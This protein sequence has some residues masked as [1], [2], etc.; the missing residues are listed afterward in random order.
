M[1]P[2]RIATTREQARNQQIHYGTGEAI[3]YYDHWTQE[4][5]PDRILTHYFVFNP[6][7]CKEKGYLQYLKEYINDTYTGNYFIDPSTKQKWVWMA[8]Q[9]KYVIPDD[10]NPPY[11]SYYIATGF[12]GQKTEGSKKIDFDLNRAEILEV[13]NRQLETK[14]NSTKNYEKLKIGYSNDM[15]N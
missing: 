15:Q 7:S 5:G 2:K 8:Y 10:P 11:Q 13:K 3:H 12:F 4:E 9:N 1:N 14:Q 6:E